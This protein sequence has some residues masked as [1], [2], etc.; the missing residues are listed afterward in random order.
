MNAI[1]DEQEIDVHTS[2]LLVKLFVVE[3][4][5]LF[6]MVIFQVLESG[7]SRVVGQARKGGRS[8]SNIPWGGGR[9][10]EE[11]L[12]DLGRCIHRKE[13]SYPITEERLGECAWNPPTGPYMHLYRVCVGVTCRGK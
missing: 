9:Y 1:R 8:E 12:Q 13:S 3:E 6:P 7:L 10:W 2:H 11:C 4:Y 5:V